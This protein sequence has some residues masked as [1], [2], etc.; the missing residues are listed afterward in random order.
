MS[1]KGIIYVEFFIEGINNRSTLDEKQTGKWASIKN[2]DTF[3]RMF[4]ILTKMFH[5]GSSFD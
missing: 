4:P 5:V 3:S 2:G 1:A